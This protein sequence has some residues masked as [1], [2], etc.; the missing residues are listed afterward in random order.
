MNI[1]ELTLKRLE[2]DKEKLKIKLTAPE[3][4]VLQ[5]PIS[6][7]SQFFQGQS[8]DPSVNSNSDPEHAYKQWLKENGLE[9]QEINQ[10]EV[11]IYGA[12]TLSNLFRSIRNKLNEEQRAAFAGIENIRDFLDSS[13]CN[14]QSKRAKLEEYYRDFVISNSTTD[15]FTKIKN[16]TKLNKITFFYEGQEIYK[17]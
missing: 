7:V 1:S 6:D 11:N 10:E 13:N 12:A 3:P 8:E 9:Q 16:Q 14:C 2:E 15:L 5:D 17:I 4:E